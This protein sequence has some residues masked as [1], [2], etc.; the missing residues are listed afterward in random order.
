MQ[1]G[2]LHLKPADNVIVGPN[3]VSNDNVGSDVIALVAILTLLSIELVL[4]NSIVI[5]LCFSLLIWF[6]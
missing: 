2:D 1:I 6:V 4:S 3:A 5:L